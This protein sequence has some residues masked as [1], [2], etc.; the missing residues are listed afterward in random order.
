MGGEKW[1]PRLWQNSAKRQAAEC[2]QHP[3]QSNDYQPAKHQL[4]FYRVA[5]NRISDVS[6]DFRLPRTSRI[7]ELLQ[8]RPAPAKHVIAIIG[9]TAFGRQ[10]VHHL[11]QD[12]RHA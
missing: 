6:V 7:H 9:Y 1:Q 4:I 12:L 8:H 3:S 5:K 11:R 2:F 10:L